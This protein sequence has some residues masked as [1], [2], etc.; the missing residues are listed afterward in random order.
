VHD[1]LGRLLYVRLN[2]FRCLLYVR[3]RY[4]VLLPQQL[5]CCLLLICKHC[6][7]FLGVRHLCELLP[8]DSS[9]VTASIA[10]SERET[11]DHRV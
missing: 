2:S 5:R 9:S 6:C 11:C 10:S 1:N 8:D 7:N 3:R 4:F